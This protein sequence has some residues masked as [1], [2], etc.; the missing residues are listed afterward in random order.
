MNKRGQGYSA[1]T[2]MEFAFLVIFAISF[3]YGIMNGID[4]RSLN[5]L[6]VED[7]SLSINSMYVVEGAV[8]LDYDFGK[9]NFNVEEENNKLRVWKDNK[10][11]MGIS[12]LGLDT[13]YEFLERVK[14]EKNKINIKKEEGSVVIS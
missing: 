11:K 4:E 8:D 6:K 7:L 3:S 1:I 2:A 12:R 5:Q 9:W 10:A 13:N 14:E